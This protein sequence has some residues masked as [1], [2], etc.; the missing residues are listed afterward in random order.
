MQAQNQDKII[1]Q[2]DMQKQEKITE[3]CK[4]ENKRE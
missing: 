4:H 1:K 2:N 3:D